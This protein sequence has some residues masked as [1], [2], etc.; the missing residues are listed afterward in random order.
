MIRILI[1]SLAF[2]DLSR[3]FFFF[4]LQRKAE[5]WNIFRNILPL[6]HI[7]T[8]PVISTEQLFAR[9]DEISFGKIELN[10]GLTGG[11]H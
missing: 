3:F 9:R 10:Q 5:F 7:S 11:G 1:K 2:L 4:F 8:F 6:P